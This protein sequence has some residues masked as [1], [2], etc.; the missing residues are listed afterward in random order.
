M[1]YLEI[2]VKI[3]RNKVTDYTLDAKLIRPQFGQNSFCVVR[4]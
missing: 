2:G 1:F 4:Q 3:T